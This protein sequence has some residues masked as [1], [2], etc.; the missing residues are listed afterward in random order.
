MRIKYT[1][2]YKRGAKPKQVTGFVRI[3]KDLPEGFRSGEMAEF[4]TKKHNLQRYHPLEIH[5]HNYTSSKFKYEN[6]K[7]V[8]RG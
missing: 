1:I 3:P 6:A 4:L 2:K 8:G 5:L 7:Q